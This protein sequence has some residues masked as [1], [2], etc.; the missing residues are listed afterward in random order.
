MCTASSLALEISTAGL[1]L[2]F[3]EAFSAVPHRPIH[4]LLARAPERLAVL[5]FLAVRTL[6][7]PKALCV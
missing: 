1:T 2:L 7:Q 3:Q 6:W 4:A 5:V